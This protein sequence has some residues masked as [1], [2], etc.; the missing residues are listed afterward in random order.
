[1]KGNYAADGEKLFLKWNRGAFTVDGGNF[2]DK[3]G[4][5]EKGVRDKDDDLKFLFL[6]EELSKQG[7]VVS[8]NVRGANYAPSVMAKMNGAKDTTR[9][10]L[11]YSM[12]RLFETGKIRVGVA[13]SYGNRTKK[14][15]IVSC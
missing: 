4:Q 2:M 7:R 1:M 8:D 9:A 5:I 10:R 13:G 12:M 15:G 14:M 6:L 3:V 11:V